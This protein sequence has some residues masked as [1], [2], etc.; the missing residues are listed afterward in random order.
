MNASCVISFPNITITNCRILNLGKGTRQ[1]T[2]DFLYDPRYNCGKHKAIFLIYIS[3][4]SNIIKNASSTI[5]NKFSQSC[6]KSSGETFFDELIPGSLVNFIF[7]ISLSNFP[8]IRNE[9]MK[10]CFHRFQCNEILYCLIFARLAQTTAAIAKLKY[11]WGNKNIFMCFKIH[12]LRFFVMSNFFVH[13]WSRRTPMKNSGKW[14]EMLNIWHP[15]C[16]VEIF[17]EQFDSVMIYT[18][19]LR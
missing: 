1:P 12:L 8:E 11:L 10:N 14:H 9:K 19:L 13:F 5:D 4:H 16:S 7:P 3:I 2:V 18:Y 15:K 17:I 6:I